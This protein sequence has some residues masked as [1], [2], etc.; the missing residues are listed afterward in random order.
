MN[1]KAWDLVDILD[2]YNVPDTSFFNFDTMR[3]DRIIEHRERGGIGNFCPPWL[4]RCLAA[5]QELLY[6][7]PMFTGMLSTSGAVSVSFMLRY[8]FFKSDLFGTAIPKTDNPPSFLM[9]HFSA[10]PELLPLYVFGMGSLAVLLP[11]GLSLYK[12]HF[13]GEMLANPAHVAANFAVQVATGI[14]PRFKGPNNTV[15]VDAYLSNPVHDVLAHR[16]VPAYDDMFMAPRYLYIYDRWLQ[17]L[18]ELI[19]EA[20]ERQEIMNIV[21]EDERRQE[22][23]EAAKARGQV[24]TGREGKEEIDV[25]N[26]FD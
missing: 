19:A 11:A 6:K 14:N 24:F 23:I 26:L 21:L 10:H 16:M 18:T 12:A 7:S 2:Y 22:A 20:D 4:I 8:L 1:N 15:D 3:P 17:Q 5:G 9:E 25:K 13:T